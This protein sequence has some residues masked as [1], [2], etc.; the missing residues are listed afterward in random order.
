ME[1]VLCIH[2]MTWSAA[3]PVVWISMMWAFGTIQA[4]SAGEV[5]PQSLAD[6]KE[7]PTPGA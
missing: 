4:Q 6:L 7:T 5:G 1:R 2:G 3:L